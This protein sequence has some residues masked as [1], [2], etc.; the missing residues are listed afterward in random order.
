MDE[1]QATE[2]VQQMMADSSEFSLKVSVHDAVA[3]LGAIQT[4]YSLAMRHPEFGT[5][6]T[7][8][9]RK[10]GQQIQHLISEKYPEAAALLETGW[11]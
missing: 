1:Q 6:A 9:L 3:V 11:L 10:I 5:Y 4:A 2:I 8:H 7:Y